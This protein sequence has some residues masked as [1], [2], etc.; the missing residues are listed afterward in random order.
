[1]PGGGTAWVLPADNRVC[2]AQETSPGGET[3]IA[4]ASGLR[5]IRFDRAEGS[6]C[7]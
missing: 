4:T 3:P 1:M 6:L 2:T 7:S 5:P